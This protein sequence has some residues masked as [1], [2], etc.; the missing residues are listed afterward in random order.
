MVETRLQK[1]KKLLK[2]VAESQAGSSHGQDDTIALMEK[3]L[4]RMEVMETSWDKKMDF[5]ARE[6]EANSKMKEEF[7][8]LWTQ[9]KYTD[10]M[11]TQLEVRVKEVEEARDHGLAEIVDLKKYLNEARD[12]IMV[13]KKAVR[14]NLG[15]GVPHVKVKEP[16]S[17]DGTRSAKTLGNFIWDMEQYLERLGLSDDETKVKVAPQFLTKDDKMLGNQLKKR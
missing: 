17:Y 6:Q 11:C 5:F 15:R 2:M 9:H 12:E 1:K 3:M 16:E 4:L 8:E 10:L 7:D 14:H 13:L